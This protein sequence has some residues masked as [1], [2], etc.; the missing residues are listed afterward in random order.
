MILRKVTKKKTA[1]DKQELSAELNYDA[2]I[3]EV[4][5]DFFRKAINKRRILK[6]GR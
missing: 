6:N 3:K 4:G 1:P 5:A 2:F